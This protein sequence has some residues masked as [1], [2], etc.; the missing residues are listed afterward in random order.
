MLVSDGRGSRLID[1]TARRR[2]GGLVTFTADD[3]YPVHTIYTAVTSTS[4]VKR[5]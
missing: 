3:H 5:S 1:A 2:G 4:P